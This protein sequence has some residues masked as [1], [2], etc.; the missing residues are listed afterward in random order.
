MV[1]REKWRDIWKVTILLEG[2]IFSTSMI[3][4]YCGEEKSDGNTSWYRSLIP[5]FTLGLTNIPSADR[6]ISRASTLH[7][8]NLTMWLRPPKPDK[9]IQNH[10]KIHHQLQSPIFLPCSYHHLPDPCSFFGR[11]LALPRSAKWCGHL[12]SIEVV[13]VIFMQGDDSTIKGGFNKYVDCHGRLIGFLILPGLFWWAVFFWLVGGWWSGDFFFWEENG[14]SD[15]RSCHWRHLKEPLVAQKVYHSI[16]GITANVY[17]ENRPF[18]QTPNR[19]PDRQNFAIQFQGR[20]LCMLVSRGVLRWYMWKKF[21]DS[22]HQSWILSW[23]VL[24]DEQMSNGYPFS[25]LNDEQMSNKVRVEHQPVRELVGNRC[26][27][28]PSPQKFLWVH[29]SESLGNWFQVCFRSIWWTPLES[30]NHRIN[31]DLLMKNI[32]QTPFVGSLDF[33]WTSSNLEG[34]F[35]LYVMSC[36]H[37]IFAV[38]FLTKFDEKIPEFWWFLKQRL[39]F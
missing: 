26:T 39:V 18:T 24:S 12:W 16:F 8:W 1:F 2:L 34:N 3:V 27:F 32:F 10:H 21:G 33:L 5:F 35:G 19:K 11:L 13:D 29:F 38:S 36:K 20:L 31:Y 9:L 15:F 37:Q 4:P 7:D 22:L 28:P 30:K 14:P 17:P 25:L 23:A 6:R